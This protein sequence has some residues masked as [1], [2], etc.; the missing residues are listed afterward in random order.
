MA[1][2]LIT[3]TLGYVWVVIASGVTGG[4]YLTGTVT[5]GP[6][7]KPSIFPAPTI[8]TSGTTMM[9]DQTSSA[10]LAQVIMTLAGGI[11]AAMAFWWAIVK[12]KELDDEFKG[13]IAGALGIVLIMILS[14]VSTHSLP[15]PMPTPMQ[16]LPGST[17]SQSQGSS[18]SRIIQP[19]FGGFSTAQPPSTDNNS[20]TPY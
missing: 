1:A 14:L 10:Q 16:G 18:G 20:V 5:A 9:A 7:I 8:I 4:P 13:W 15:V 12:L 6:A 2:I 3:A 19:G 11:P 17:Q